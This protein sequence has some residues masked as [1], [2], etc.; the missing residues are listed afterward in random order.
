[1]IS[2]RHLKIGFRYIAYRFNRLHPYEVQAQLL[3]ACD[4]RCIYCRCPDVKTQ[5]LKSDQ[6][7]MILHSLGNLGTLRVKF[8]GGEPTLHP[9]FRQLCAEA[10]N[11]GLLTAT[12]TNGVRISSRPALLD[13]LDELVVSLDSL[14]PEVN[15]YLRG[16]GAYDK[17]VK[18]IRI[19]QERGVHTYISMAVC[20]CNISDVAAMLDFCEERGIM[21]NAQPVI[22]GR[23]YYDDKAKN[24]GLS[25]DQIRLVHQKQA[26][27][28]QQGRNILFSPQA[29]LKAL[30]W[31]DLANLTSKSEE[32][33]ACRAGKDYVHIEPNGDV[34]PCIQHGADFTPKNILRDGIYESF[35]HVQH[36]NCGDCWSAYLNER[37]LL[38]GLK[39]SAMRE[40]IRR[41]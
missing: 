20:Q 6:W 9:D 16:K 30:T 18:A 33:S 36:H 25:P 40:M 22:F 31:P 24:I 5:L 14:K 2:L 10:K 19:S 7:K 3:N 23:D 26:E 21:M 32:E 39:P 28:K 17:A 15:D 27:W 4:M 13:Y 11:A 8:Q 12:V 35:Y 1:M 29:Y 34:W 41:G 38:F 37:K